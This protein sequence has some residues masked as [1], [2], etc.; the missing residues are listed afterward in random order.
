M[1]PRQ[2]TALLAMAA[3]WGG[4]FLY[5]RV[6][7][8]A[9]I[10]PTG[11][12]GIRTVVGMLSL[13]PVAIAM[14]RQFPRD[15]RT[16][17]A[18]LALG[19]LNFAV[20]WTLVA[21]SEEHIPSGV[22]SIVNSA[23]PLWT[24]IFA[25]ALIRNERLTAVQVMG[26]VL[27]FLGVVALLGEDLADLGGDSARGVALMLLA[28]A[29]AGLSSVIIRRWLL[30]V[31]P[32]PLTIGQ[33]GFASCMLVPL[34]IGSGAYDGASFGL[35][36]AASALALGGLGSGVAVVAFMWLIGQIGAVRAVVVTYLIPPIGV[37]LGWAVL[38]E[39][40]G[41]NLVLGLSLVAGGVALVQGVPVL[42]PILRP[43]QSRPM[44]AEI[45]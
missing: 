8:D 42:R 14:R 4:S 37:F 41:W 38:D 26:L 31:P 23:M 5:V 17:L 15:G 13:L 10:A 24:A 33:V 35:K 21:M 32:L 3:I 29:C 18:L 22:A 11:I 2:L 6:L 30:H 39:P 12:S 27:G 36:E 28:T 25:V 20:P 34:A 44:P 1:T 19:F 16:W 43:A 45:E 40:I 9:G 7:I